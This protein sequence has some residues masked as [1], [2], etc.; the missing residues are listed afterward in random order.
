MLFPVPIIVK[1]IRTLVF[2]NFFN[3]PLNAGT[4]PYP[5]K[6]NLQ[7]SLGKTN[8]L[9]SFI[10]GFS[11]GKERIGLTKDHGESDVIGHC[12][13]ARDPVAMLGFNQKKL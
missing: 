7:I 1:V 11:M 8:A 5:L 13:G 2:E 4:P 9:E 10:S 12:E 3:S 6:L